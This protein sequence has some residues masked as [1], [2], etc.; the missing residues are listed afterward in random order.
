MTS[1][2][3]G[4]GQDGAGAANAGGQCALVDWAVGTR[5][6]QA[7]RSLPLPGVVRVP[8]LG[9]GLRLSGVGRAL[10]GVGRGPGPEE[11]GLKLPRLE[12][13]LGSLVM[14]LEKECFHLF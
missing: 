4:Q 1:E 3:A 14:A 8:S 5:K 10:S 11:N 9:Q 2:R 7:Q 13:E 6:L 12:S